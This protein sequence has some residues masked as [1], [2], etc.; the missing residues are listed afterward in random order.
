VVPIERL[1][2]PFQLMPNPSPFLSCSALQL[3]ESF[4]NHSLLRCCA[5]L[6]GGQSLTKRERA[7][8]Q[9]IQQSTEGKTILTQ[10]WSTPQRYAQEYGV[11][12]PRH[13]EMQVV[14]T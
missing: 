6:G 14:F 12:V 7:E 13:A 9:L 4:G 10:T 2:G 1:L 3:G 11:K 8:A 5:A